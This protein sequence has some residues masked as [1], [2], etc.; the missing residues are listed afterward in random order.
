LVEGL[1]KELAKKQRNEQLNQFE[2]L[3]LHGTDIAAN[4]RNESEVANRLDYLY[5]NFRH[6]QDIILVIDDLS[7]LLPPHLRPENTL[8]RLDKHLSSNTPPTIVT[9]TAE[10]WQSLMNQNGYLSGRF[11]VVSVDGL[12]KMDC[13]AITKAW[14]ERIG[15]IQHLNF[16]ADAIAEIENILAERKKLQPVL[17]ATI[18]DLVEIVATYVKVKSFES[19]NAP[20]AVGA[21]DVR[22][23]IEEY[24][25]K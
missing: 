8:A 3:E 14:V 20:H 12:N 11:N 22:R 16:A 4:C 21:D 6:N 5:D 18:V 10:F 2:I 13:H 17:P 19:P 1:A 25:G 9:T 24:D 7:G 15:F 23:A